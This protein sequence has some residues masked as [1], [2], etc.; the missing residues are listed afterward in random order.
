MSKIVETPYRASH[1]KQNETL[2][3]DKH[4]ASLY[5][6]KFINPKFLEVNNKL[7]SNNISLTINELGRQLRRFNSAPSLIL[8]VLVNAE[9][10]KTKIINEEGIVIKLFTN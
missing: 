8:D 1:E 2:M 4:Q 10:E 3:R 6:T 5:R 7:I 9:A